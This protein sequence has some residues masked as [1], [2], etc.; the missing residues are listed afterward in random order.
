MTKK[1]KSASL[2]VVRVL[3]DNLDAGFSVEWC[4]SE[5]WCSRLE[6]EQSREGSPHSSGSFR[7]QT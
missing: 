2:D 5:S 1:T 7:H 4:L 6:G 3:A